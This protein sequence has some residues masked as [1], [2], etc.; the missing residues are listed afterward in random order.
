MCQ[1]RPGEDLRAAGVSTPRREARSRALWKNARRMSE[2]FQK[3]DRS[4]SG[5][6]GLL[7]DARSA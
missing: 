3:K 1:D 5:A 2:G 4:R 7:I 6:A